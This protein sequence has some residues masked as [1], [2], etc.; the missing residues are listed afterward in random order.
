MNVFNSKP[1]LSK[2]KCI[3]D[4]EIVGGIVHEFVMYIQTWGRGDFLAALSSRPDTE[5]KKIVDDLFARMETQVR[6]EPTFYRHDTP[7]AHIMMRKI[8]E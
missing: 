7:V 3:S 8:C 5:R 2:S 4:P 6:A 1:C